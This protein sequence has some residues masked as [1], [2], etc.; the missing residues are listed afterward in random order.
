MHIN[1]TITIIIEGE[2]DS[3]TLKLSKD[4]YLLSVSVTEVQ[5]ISSLWLQN[6][7]YFFHGRL[8]KPQ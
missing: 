7:R 1:T 3:D 5:Y 4:M 6:N 2:L 8:L